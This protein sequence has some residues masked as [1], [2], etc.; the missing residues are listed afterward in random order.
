M[1]TALYPVLFSGSLD[2]EVV[3]WRSAIAA[4]GGSVSGGAVAAVN[5]FVRGCKAD[6]VWDALL[7]VGLF[8]GVD[9]LNAALV[10]LK[11]PSG[12]QRVLTN[13]NFV[14]AD[15][16][17]TGASAGLV[18]N[19]SSKFLNTGFIGLGTL[20]TT[21]ASVGFYTTSPHVGLSVTGAG[22]HSGSRF[23]VT[24]A[25]TGIESHLFNTTIGGGALSLSGAPTA[26]HIIASRVA[27]NSHIIYSNGSQVASNAGSGGSISGLAFFLY[28]FNNNG[29]PGS[30]SPQRDTFYHIGRGLSAANAAALASRVNDLMRAFGANV[31]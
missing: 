3:A 17:A 18:G 25:P 23:N 19:G 10:K 24:N 22:E 2:P 20:S 12:V 30:F 21:S 5:A 16:T 29:T 28:A 13:N 14:S 1:L 4:N 6:G 26:R 27:S 11:T 31:Y 15:H 8:A 9:N 7:D